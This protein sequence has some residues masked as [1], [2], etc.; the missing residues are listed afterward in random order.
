MDARIAAL[1]EQAGCSG[2][3]SRAGPWACPM[4]PAYGPA[5]ALRSRRPAS[6]SRPPF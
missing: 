6:R 1:S 2:P 5:P 4:P 3:S